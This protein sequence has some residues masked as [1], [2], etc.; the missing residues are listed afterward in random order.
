MKDQVRQYSCDAMRKCELNSKSVTF[1][2]SEI[3]RFSFF[4]RIS[5]IL[6]IPPL[7]CILNTKSCYFRMFSYPSFKDVFLNGALERPSARPKIN[8]SGY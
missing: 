7:K 3:N 8:I 1:V 5:H 2:F 4:T 6:P